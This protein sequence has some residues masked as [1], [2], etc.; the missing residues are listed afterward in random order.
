MIVDKEMGEK[1]VKGDFGQ[2]DVVAGALNSIAC[3]TGPSCTWNDP[4]AES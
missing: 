4:W 1:G 2:I 3:S